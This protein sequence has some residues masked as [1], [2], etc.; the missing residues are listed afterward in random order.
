M[1]LL[2]ERKSAKI[3]QGEPW[4]LYEVK[5]PILNEEEKE[6]L[7]FISDAVSNSYS[8]RDFQNVIFKDKKKTKITEKLQELID[9]LKPYFNAISLEKYQSKIMSIISDFVN[10]Q[11]EIKHTDAVQKEIYNIIIGHGKL[12]YF[13]PDDELE[14]IMVNGYGKPIFVFD[15]NFGLCKT[16]VKYNTEE[17]ILA[18]IHKV[19]GFIGREIGSDTPVLDAR[20]PDG[21]RVNA[22]I[23]PAS[24]MGATITVRK[25]RRRPYTI[26]EIIENNTMTSELAA[27]MWMCVEGM[28]LRPLNFVISGGTGSGK[29]TT[30]NALS[31][32]IP[33]R[34]RVVTIE[35]TLEL[36]LYDRQNWIQLEAKTIEGTAD[37][38]DLLKTSIRM[39]PDRILVGEVRGKEAS[40][41]FTAMDVGHQGMIS[42]LHSNS[43][44]ETILRLRSEPMS[45]PLSMFVLLDMIMMQHRMHVAGK[46]VIRRVTQVSE[47][48][49]MGDNILLND[50][51]MLDRDADV[52]RRTDIPIQI[53]EKFSYLT[54][55]KIPEI[56]AELK[57][58][59]AV[60]EHFVKNDIRDYTKIRDIVN[61][62]ISD[63]EKT[64][65]QLKV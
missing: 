28:G 34:E 1:E 6:M 37:L 57:Q 65:K 63:P 18:T 47:I 46:G 25:F 21:S 17:E 30:L 36:N 56:K 55:K 42:T 12:E 61:D 40:T 14:E 8:A 51:Y 9:S 23:P 38:N 59:Q 11:K 7:S 35:D 58:R 33:E 15:R 50:I 13:L 44:K 27:F 43:A 32:F 45:V 20:L 24:P 49:V 26:T 53:I 31:V 39:R 22:T 52:V 4:N 41:M 3:Y 48:S 5:L 64:M 60:L 2:C 29:T 54:G 10:S 19:S 16:N 62:Y